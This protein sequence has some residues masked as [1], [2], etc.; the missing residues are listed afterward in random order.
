MA[1]LQPD[2]DLA[3]HPVVQAFFTLQNT[4]GQALELPGLIMRW[5]EQDS[6]TAKFD[7]SLTVDEVGDSL[8]AVFEYPGELFDAGTI[9]GL[10]QSYLRLLRGLVDAPARPVLGLPLL[11]GGTALPVPQ[12]YAFRSVTERV[13]AQCGRDPAATA[14]VHEDQRL[15]YGGLQDLSGRMAWALRR[16]G[17]G[18]DVRVGLCMERSTGLVASLLGILRS[19]GAYVPLDPAYPEARLRDTIADAGLHCIVADRASA[20]R[21][22][23]LLDG[24]RLV[25]LED[26]VEAAVPFGDAAPH[27][28]QL[29]YVIYTSGSTGKPKGVGVSH[30]NVARLLDL[31]ENWFGFGPSDVWTLFHSYAFDFSVW[32]IFGALAY[33]GRLVVVPHWTARDTQAFHDLL[34]TEGVTVLNQTPS[35]FLPLMHLDIASGQP[36]TAL[37]TVIFGGE[38][39]EPSTLAPLIAARGEAAPTLI[40]MYGITETTGCMPLIVAWARPRSCR[41]AHAA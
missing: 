40:N 19:G 18:A 3:H 37:R 5:I 4:P 24:Q 6:V 21:L 36:L 30:A 1:A 11:D 7:L 29:A 20:E 38:K 22:S 35:A 28:L 32:E 12:R 16:L 2:R 14:V 23:S 34:R 39:L 27:P 9:E 8:R 41:R 15:S 33:G 31:T 13:L 25:V 10:S 17:V 26:L